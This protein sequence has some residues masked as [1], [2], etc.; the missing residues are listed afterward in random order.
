M[1]VFGSSVQLANWF[2]VKLGPGLSLRNLA[3]AVWH[4]EHAEGQ[5]LLDLLS[6]ATDELILGRCLPLEG[7]RLVGL[8]CAPLECFPVNSDSLLLLRVLVPI[9]LVHLVCEG[10]LVCRLSTYFAIPG[11]EAIDWP[12]ICLRQATMLRESHSV[13][14]IVGEGASDAI[15]CLTNRCLSTHVAFSIRSHCANHSCTL[16]VSE[17]KVVRRRESHWRLIGYLELSTLLL[18]VENLSFLTRAPLI[19]HHPIA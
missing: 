7:Q 5:N 6:L 8:Q 17:G 3:H 2:L 11:L 13:T 14:A 4:N 18:E 15:L 10:L 9:L 19:V 12:L 1:I 16:G